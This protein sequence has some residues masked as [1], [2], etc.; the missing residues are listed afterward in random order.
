MTDE[1]IKKVVRMTVK[2][3]KKEGMTKEFSDVMFEEM[4]K[5]LFYHFNEGYSEDIAKALNDIKTDIYYSIIPMYYGKRM[6]HETIAE[7]MGVEVSTI[8]RN[9]KRL[10][11]E[12]Y[13]MLD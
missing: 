13:R 5:K 7:K 4:S 1:E 2:A 3:M 6:T 11:I 8:T 9:K 12:I 10:C